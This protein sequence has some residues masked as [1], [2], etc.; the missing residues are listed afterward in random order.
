[1]LTHG[2]QH[3]QMNDL[4]W[5]AFLLSNCGKPTLVIQIGLCHAQSINYT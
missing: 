4:A 3:K 5:Q 2:Y 1:M